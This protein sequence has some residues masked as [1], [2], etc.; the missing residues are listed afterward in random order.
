MK[1]LITTIGTFTLTAAIAASAA[2]CTTQEAA[3]PVG[4]VQANRE[5]VYALSMITG[6]NFLSE[7]TEPEQS[8]VFR[9]SARSASRT[10]PAADEPAT[11]RPETFGSDVPALNGYLNTFEG[12][13]SAK[14]LEPVVAV[15]TEED[16]EYAVYDT[17]LTISLSGESYVLYYNEISV[18]N[19]TNI[20]ISEENE[21]EEFEAEEPEREESL[22]K[23]ATDQT[24]DEKK[25][26]KEER[27]ETETKIKLEGVLLAR[28]RVFDISGK[29]EIEIKGDRY[30]SEIEF[31]TKSKQ[32]SSDYVT[33]KQSVESKQD[34]QEI[35]YEYSVYRDGQ[36]TGNTKVEWEQDEEDGE[37]ELTVQF[38]QNDGTLQE[39]K[40]SFLLKG[41]SITVKVRGD[42]WKDRFTVEIRENAYFYTYSNGY[43]EELPR[44]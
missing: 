18:K 34:K 25:Q 16:G 35:E 19:K 40:Y 3:A 14:E 26:E 20:K 9:L 39:T 17:K 23:D 33:V 10:E 43:T 36:C 6:A 29:R 27:E 21:K 8:S 2:A 1:K 22:S 38:K 41:S 11:A 32:N 7:S 13:L 12:I 4:P 5:S 44:G 15:P 37:S 24:A 31:T 30:E 42:Q 28:D